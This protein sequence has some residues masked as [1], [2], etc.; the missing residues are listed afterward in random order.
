M[1]S[2]VLE[3][4]KELTDIGATVIAS[5]PLSSPSISDSGDLKKYEKLVAEIF[6][7]NKGVPTTTGVKGKVIWR[8]NI[9]EI[10]DALNILPDFEVNEKNI[11]IAWTH[12]KL[13]EDHIYFVSSQ[14]KE[15]INTA[16]KFKIKRGYEA[17]IWRPET[18]DISKINF[19]YTKDERAM[20][21]LDFEPEEACHLGISQCPVE[22]ASYGN[23][24]ILYQRAQLVV[25]RFRVEP[26]RYAHGAQERLVSTIPYA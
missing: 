6:D 8:K 12:R 10:V 16:C 19:K 3:K 25:R 2:S 1:M 15:S 11:E 24:R 17:E 5:K 22:I 21:N 7:G 4:I 20:L 26:P 23:F 18:G 13:E 14:M 9:D